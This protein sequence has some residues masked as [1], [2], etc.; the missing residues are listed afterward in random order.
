MP[1]LVTVAS[2]TAATISRTIGATSDLTMTTQCGWSWRIRVS[3]GS[4]SRV[5]GGYSPST[6]WRQE[7]TD[8]CAGRQVRPVSDGALQRATPHDEANRHYAGQE[9]AVEDRLDG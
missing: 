3:P 4:K 6:R 2:I 9:D 8:D 7:Q 1:V 5:I